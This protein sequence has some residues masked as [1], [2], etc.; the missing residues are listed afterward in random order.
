MWPVWSDKC[1]YVFIKNRTDTPRFVPNSPARLRIWTSS[2]DF[3]NG[4]LMENNGAEDRRQ[5]T[6][7]V[8]VCNK[9]GLLRW[10]PA[11]FPVNWNEDPTRQNQVAVW[12][13]YEVFVTPYTHPPKCKLSFFI[14]GPRV[15]SACKHVRSYYSQLSD[16]HGHVNWPTDSS[17]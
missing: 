13:Q 3:Q 4:S 15:W 16:S 2:F 14:Q 10:W 5:Q 9:E 8:A 12:R 1:S 6:W 17:V 7:R 11:K